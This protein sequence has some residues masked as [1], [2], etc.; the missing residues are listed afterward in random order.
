MKLDRDKIDQIGKTFDLDFVIFYGSQAVGKREG[1][2]TDVDIAVYRRGGFAPDEYLDLFAQMADALDGGELD[3]KSLSRRNALFQYN[4]IQNGKLLY[5]DETGYN[6]FKAYIYR[7]YVDI[8]PLL[9]L[10]ED[11]VNRYQQELKND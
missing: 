9:K 11:L 4:V 2:E 8:Q 10:Q 6:H 7:K 3:M 5:G 1:P